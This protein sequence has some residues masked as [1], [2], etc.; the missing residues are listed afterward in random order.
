[1]VYSSQVGPSIWDLY[2]NFGVLQRIHIYTYAITNLLAFLPHV[3]VLGPQLNEVS[4]LAVAHV[5]VYMDGLVAYLTQI[6]I[7]EWYVLRCSSMNEYQI[8]WTFNESR[9][10]A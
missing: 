1:M 9:V 3:L 7:F 2:A 6:L 5:K 8:E 4:S 10:H